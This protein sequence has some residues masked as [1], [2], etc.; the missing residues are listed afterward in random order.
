MKPAA[1][2]STLFLL[3]AS[4]VKG[5]FTLL[6]QIGFEN[7]KVNVDQNFS[8]QQYYAAN[9]SLGSSVVN[10]KANLRL[11]YRFRNGFGPYISVGTK[12]AVYEYKV[13]N[14]FGIGNVT[15][16]KSNLQWKL[17]GGYQYT[18]KQFKL[19]RSSKSTN[20]STSAQKTYTHSTC[21]SYYRCGAGTQ[22]AKGS[23]K[24][25]GVRL[26]P[27]IGFAYDPSTTDNI[28]TKNNSGMPTIILPQMFSSTAYTAGDWNTAVVSG[29]SFELGQ[30]K[31]RLMTLSVIYTHGIGN[32]GSKTIDEDVAVK[33]YQHSYSSTSNNWGLTLGI[34][35][36]LAKKQHTTS[37]AT[38]Y[39][40][41]ENS[42]CRSRCDSYRKCTRR[43]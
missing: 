31:Q 7:S 43:I 42:G 16:A 14:N 22:K 29:M 41:N 10:F 26:Q 33:P 23:N 9:P 13:D 2:V 5:Q 18:S 39:K 25:L 38:S 35:I 27:S 40:T 1:L 12:P 19:A 30:G 15:S 17:E 4:T 21:G 28:V 20:K 3:C 8:S 11:D 36:G 37:K 34:P 6:P 32:L 24:D